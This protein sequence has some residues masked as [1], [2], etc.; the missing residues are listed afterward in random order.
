V[1]HKGPARQ[2]ACGTRPAAAQLILSTPRTDP[3]QAEP[4]ADRGDINGGLVATASLSHRVAAT[5]VALE[6]A[7][8][9]LDQPGWLVQTDRWAGS[10]A[11]CTTLARSPGTAARS[12]ASFEPG[13]ERGHRGLAVIPGLVEPPVHPAA[14]FGLL[15]SLGRRA[16]GGSGRHRAA[17]QGRDDRPLSGGRLPGRGGS[18]PLC[19][20][21][22]GTRGFPG[23][24][25]IPI[26][27][28]PCWWCAPIPC[29][30]EPGVGGLGGAGALM[31]RR[32]GGG[33]RSGSAA[34][35]AG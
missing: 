7:G 5:P 35:P 31:A 2:R 25:R 21:R 33:R 6:P 30:P 19:L 29:C 3:V 8:L 14:A 18:A 24:R 9:R 11:A 16:A 4:L 28:G 12:T 17:A 27:A 34:P 32:P 15:F 20:K 22:V 13:C 26:G 23:W 1:S 10:S